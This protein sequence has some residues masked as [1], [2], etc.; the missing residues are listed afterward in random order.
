[1][2]SFKKCIIAEDCHIILILT[3][4]LGFAYYA[5]FA[6]LTPQTLLRHATRQ[7]DGL[8]VDPATGF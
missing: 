7:P 8:G 3:S 5:L 6:F 1:M 2:F 4:K